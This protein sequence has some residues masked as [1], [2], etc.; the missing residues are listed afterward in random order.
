M[1]ITVVT[2]YDSSNY[3]AYL[4]A[5]CLKY[6]LEK[7]GH[8]VVHVP[9]RDAEYVRNLYYRDKPLSKK[10]KLMPWK[11]RKKV[12]FGKHKLSLFQPDQ[13]VFRVVDP[14]KS[15]SDL[16]ILGSDE[17]WNVTQ[18]AFRKPIFWGAGL[19]PVISYA[20]SIGKAEIEGFEKFPEQINGLRKL[21]SIL[22]RDER[23]K[24][25]VQKYASA[26]AQ[27][28]CDPTMLVPVEEYGKAFSDSYIEQ[29]DC[30]LIY[31]YRLK[32]EVQKSIQNYARKKNLKTV[33]CCFQHDW[34][35]YQCE[36]SP[37][38]FSAL[39]R[40][41]K[42][43]ITTTFHGSI[44]SILNHARFVSIPTSPKTNQLMAQFD[45]ES[46]LLPEEKVNADTIEAILDGQKI[47]YDEVESKIRGIRERSAEALRTAV[48]TACA[49]K[50]KFDYQICPSDDCTGCFACMNKCP[51]QAIHCVTDGLGRTLPQIDPATCVQ[52]GLCKKVCPQVNPVECR[53]PMECYAAQRPDESI[54]KKS[55]S[56][57]IGAALTEQFMNSGGVVYGAAVQNGGEVVHMRAD[58]PQQAEKFRNSKY[59]QSYIG[60]NYT[61]VLRQLKDGKKVLFTGTPCQ[62]AGLRSFLG[63]EYD[64]L[65]CVDIICHGVP[66]MQY[67]KQHMKT[68]IGDKEVDE[69]SFRGGDKDYHLNIG[70]QGQ[71]VYSRK[72]YRDYYY[73]AFYRGLIHRENCYHCSYAQS[74]R[75][76]DMT[77][78]DFWGLQRKTLKTE[79]TGNISVALINTEKGRELIRLIQDQIVWEP[80]EVSEAV[81]GNSQLRRPSV[82][83]KKRKTFVQA[84]YKTGDFTQS[85]KSV[86]LKKEL[87]IANVKRTKLWRCLGRAK[88]KL[89]H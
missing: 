89:I 30:L 16:Y 26:D 14:E 2:P 42:A 62:I 6:Y 10:D 5:F 46:R 37:L 35:D 76:S 34:C 75:C 61:D 49:E 73:Y 59:V 8:E 77:I 65:Y 48:E 70:Y 81:Q 18:P 68:V 74:G 50:E 60:D 66:P 44:F 27:I 56:G 1:K 13:E 29:N 84:Y 86:N 15:E 25:F 52:C 55:A 12:E 7:E 40:K 3:G 33:A 85:I 31:A 43:V 83:H 21:S 17:I 69:L 11:F 19:S 58:T 32:K 64:N 39:I 4:Q 79:Q 80:R 24:E 78:G 28:V 57:G 45:L 72:Q 23:T 9:T 82:L 87:L 71:L 53:E 38:Q 36:C 47:D 51:K 54:R 20:A 63:K 67:L 88:Q 22:V 41:C